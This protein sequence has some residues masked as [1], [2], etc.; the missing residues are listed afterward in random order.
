MYRYL[1]STLISLT[2]DKIEGVVLKK[3]CGPNR[4]KHLSYYVNFS[5]VEE[6]RIQVYHEQNLQTFGELPKTWRK[7]FFLLWGSF[8]PFL[9][10]GLLIYTDQLESGSLNS[11]YRMRYST[12][13]HYCR[14]VFT[15]PTVFFWLRLRGAVNPKLWFRIRNRNQLQLNF[16]LMRQI[17]KIWTKIYR[18]RP[19]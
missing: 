6:F 14:A 7:F 3:T 13:N 4:D 1:D 5:S 16:C 15:V 9:D 2:N 8:W 17:S 10:Q 11:P 19:K 12:F 18:T